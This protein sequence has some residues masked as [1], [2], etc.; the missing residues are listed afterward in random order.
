MAKITYENKEFLNK[1]ENIANKNKVNDTDLNEIK[2][3][4]NQNDDNIGNLS[5]LNTTNKD[6]LVGAINE[7][8]SK[9]EVVFDYIVNTETNII[10]YSSSGPIL[11]VG[12]QFRIYISG[13]ATAKTDVYTLVD[14]YEGLQYYQMGNYFSNNLN[15]DGTI[16]QI[17]GYRPAK[18]GFYY[19]QNMGLDLSRISGVMNLQLSASGKYYPFYEY[20]GKSLYSG[21]QFMAE[22]FGWLNVAKNSIS[23]LTFKCA[24]GN[25][26]VGTKVKIIK[27]KANF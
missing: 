5:N 16:P 8:N 26:K 2:N 12:E 10:T 25:F 6:S 1:N 17:S 15:A 27:E 23:S 20:K 22:G 13:S 24:N 3:I 19:G 4:V 21:N 18:N 14:G 7:V 9:E 11:S